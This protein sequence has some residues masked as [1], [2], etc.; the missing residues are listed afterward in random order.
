MQVGTISLLFIQ[1][2]GCSGHKE[3]W[4]TGNDRIDIRV[5]L[6]PTMDEVGRFAQDPNFWFPVCH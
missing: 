5:T 4:P 6:W 1:I 3:L 2:S